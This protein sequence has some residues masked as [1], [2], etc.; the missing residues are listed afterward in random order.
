[1]KRLL[2]TAAAALLP[3]AVAAQDAPSPASPA[4]AIAGSTAAT[5]SVDLGADRITIGLA[6]ALVPGYSGSNNYTLV[7][8]IAVQGQVSGIAFNT[9]GTSLYVDAIPG[10]GGVGWKVQLGPLANLRLDRHT[11]IGDAQVEA[12]GKLNPAYELG[13]WGGVQRTGVVTSSY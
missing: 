1:M 9:Q 11:L 8:G 2:A 7:P 10:H 12:L 5:P 6:A 4:P 3:T 13:V